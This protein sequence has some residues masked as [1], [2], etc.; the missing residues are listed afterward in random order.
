[1]SQTAES[2]VGT[3]V[4]VVLVFFICLLSFSVGIFIGKKFSDNQYQLAKLKGEFSNSLMADLTSKEQ[5]LETDIQEAELSNE[6]TANFAAEFAQGESQDR[7]DLFKENS[8]PS[9]K[10]KEESAQSLNSVASTT[11]DLSLDPSNNKQDSKNSESIKNREIAS[12]ENEAPAKKIAKEITESSLTKYTIQVAAFPTEAEASKLTSE[13]KNKG[14][15]SYFLAAQVPEKKG[16]DVLKT[17]Y[18]VHVGLFH[19]TKEAEEVK[20]ELIGHKKIRNGMVKKL[21]E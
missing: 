3:V 6:E 1:M 18:R 9:I 10:S 15:E 19:S 8:Q 17:W 13:L 11:R 16:S 14:L 20:N 2:K 21:S 5:S 4:L 7:S 12:T